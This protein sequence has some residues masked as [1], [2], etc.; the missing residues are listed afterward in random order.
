MDPVT[1]AVVRGSLQQ[2]AD[3]MDVHLTR[4]AISPVIAEMNDCANG[5]YHAENGETITQGQYGLPVFLAAMQFVVQAIIEAAKARGGFKPG[6]IWIMNDPYLGGTHLSDINMVAPYFVDGKLF[7]LLANTGHLIDIGGSQPGGFTPSATEVLQEGMVIPPVRLYRDGKI[8]QD[9]LNLVLANNRLPREVNGDI[10]AMA[11]V[12][13]IGIGLLDRVVTRHGAS[14]VASCIGEMIDRSEKQMRSYISE[15]PDGVF[16]FEDWLD[17]DGISDS[18]LK[19]AL[20]VTVSGT[21]LKFDFTGTSPLPRGPMSLSRNTAISTCYVALKHIFPDVPVNGGAFRPTQFVIPDRCLI[22]AEAPHPV[23]GYLEIVSRIIDVVFGALA[24][25]IP[26]QVPAA[27]FGTAGALIFSGHNPNTGRYFIGGYPYPGGYGATRQSDG[28]VNGVSP[29]S[30]ANFMSLELSEH[31]FP[32]RFD[33][34]AIREDSGGA[35]RNRGGCGTEYV[36]TP[37]SPLQV[38]IFGDR[39]DH[40]PFGI[41]GG[42]AGGAN[43]VAV[44]SDGKEWVPPFRS[45][46]QALPLTPEQSLLVRT[47]GGGG[48]GDPLERGPAEVEVDLNQGQ[49]SRKTAEKAY[50]VVARVVEHVGERPVYRVDEEATRQLRAEKRT[51]QP[52][53][54]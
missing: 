27:F 49:I 22:A 20:K 50:G 40:A 2:V 35:G 5:I 53:A 45:K 23:G 46:H 14:T 6:D 10:L 52:Q 15:F 30:L 11:N 9:V 19:I 18:P 39:V 24:Q 36:V 4:A 43:H 48:Y 26:D 12:F 25:A 38:T 42:H 51:R 34:F 8:D 17:N 44:L 37:T 31:R 1:L 7:A 47:P 16:T 29:Q 33:S 32:F 21:D 41:V 28:L 3:E 54:F 13:D